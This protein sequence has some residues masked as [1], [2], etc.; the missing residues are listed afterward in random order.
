[1]L[2][3]PGGIFTDSFLVRR[4]RPCPR[5]VSQGFLTTLPLPRQ[6]GQ[7]CWKFSM[8]PID[9][10]TCPVPWQVSQVEGLD[11]FAAPEPWQVSHS[12]SFG[13]SISTLVPNTACCSDSSS[14]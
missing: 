7:A 14:S 13:T 10:R 11:P 6:R 2:S 8:P 3:T 5:Q 12:P 1:P 4:T 9:M